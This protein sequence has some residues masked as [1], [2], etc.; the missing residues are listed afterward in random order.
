[1]VTIIIASL[2]RNPSQHNRYKLQQQQQHSYSF[3]LNISNNNK[4]QFKISTT[5]DPADFYFRSLLRYVRSG[6]L[7]NYFEKLEFILKQCPIICPKLTVSA[8]A[9]ASTTPNSLLSSNSTNNNSASTNET[10]NVKTMPSVSLTSNCING[11]PSMSP[12]SSRSW[13]M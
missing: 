11:L 5:N 2:Y 7:D 8:A 12:T 6:N 10:N 1:M 13:S 9:A 3:H 4:Q